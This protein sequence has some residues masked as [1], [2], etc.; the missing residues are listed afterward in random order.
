MNINNP[1]NATTFEEDKHRLENKKL[2][3]KM[4]INGQKN[5]YNSKLLN[6]TK[7]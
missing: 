5:P 1:K 3:G 2:E 7:F 6:R 4:L